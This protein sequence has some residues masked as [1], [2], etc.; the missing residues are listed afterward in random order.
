MPLTVHHGGRAVDRK[1]WGHTFE[2]LVWG[3]ESLFQVQVYIPDASSSMTALNVMSLIQVPFIVASD[4]YKTICHI[5]SAPSLFDCAYT[6]CTT[7]EK[8]SNAGLVYC[9]HEAE[10]NRAVSAE[11]CKPDF[12]QQN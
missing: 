7:S 6:T 12:N 10:A 9:G 3:S 11:H 1:L 4:S 2:Q 8:V 5:T